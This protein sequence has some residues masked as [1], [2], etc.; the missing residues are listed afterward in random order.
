MTD[1]HERLNPSLRSGR[2]TGIR[3]SCSWRSR[4]QSFAE[5]LAEVGAVVLDLNG[6]A[7]CDGDGHPGLTFYRLT[8]PV[9]M[10]GAEPLTHWAIC[11]VTHGP[12]LMLYRQPIP[13][14]D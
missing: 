10:P 9:D 2:T 12:I 8:R 1:L 6:C 4:T 11:P 14:E 13:E 3:C 7:R 5:H